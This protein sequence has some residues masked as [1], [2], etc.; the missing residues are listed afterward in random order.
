M[1]IAE[2]FSGTATIST[3]EYDLPSNST[4]LGSQ[5]TD[6]I[7]QV[8][9]DLNAL[10]ATEEYRLRIYEKA[11]S[12]STQRVVQ[13]VIISGVQSEPIYVTPALLFLHGWTISLKKNQGTDRSII[14]SIRQV[15]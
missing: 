6:G 8:F 10:T 15:A 4:T 5:T 9:L 3:T 2:S 11:I 14:W 1:A 12:S 13:E 7:Y